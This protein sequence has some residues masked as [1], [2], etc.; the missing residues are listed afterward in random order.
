VLQAQNW[1]PRAQGSIR[2]GLA[3]GGVDVLHQ[4][5]SARVRFPRPAAEAIEAVL[6]N[7]AGGLTGGDR[8]DIAISLSRGAQASVTTAAAE[9]V[10]RARDAEPALVSVS[11]TLEHGAHLYWLP[12]PTILFNRARL[13]RRTEIVLAD[14]ASLLALEILIFG[15]AAMGEQVALGAVY[16]AW[17]VRRA[18]ALV[19]ADTFRLEGAIAEILRHEATLNGARANA[20]LLYVAA[21]AAERLDAVRARTQA[22]GAAA[23]ASTFNGLLVVRAIGDDGGLLQRQMGELAA[24]LGARPLPRAWQA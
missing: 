12:Q 5:G 7:T 17:R 22:L 20:L 2:L 23:G 19:F 4:A 16:D 15:R 14:D 21:D 3:N 11:L 24:W 6:L 9:K 18:G 10:Y 1:L 13:R 8:L